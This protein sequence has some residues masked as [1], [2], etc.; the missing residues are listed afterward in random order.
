MAWLRGKIRRREALGT[1]VKGLASLFATPLFA[2]S[3]EPK[4]Q[5]RSGGVVARPIAGPVSV[6]S[7]FDLP[8]DPRSRELSGISWDASTRTLWA[9]QDEAPRIVALH[10]DDDLVRWS[11]GESVNVNVPGPLDLEGLVVIPE[12]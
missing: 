1:L 3:S 11:F 7:F 8:E 4:P 2:C 12:G 5:A 6:H 10:P 9:V